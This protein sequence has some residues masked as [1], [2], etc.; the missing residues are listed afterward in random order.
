MHGESTRGGVRQRLWDSG[1]KHWSFGRSRTGSV[2]SGT[3]LRAS[4][5][6]TAFNIS[7]CRFTAIVGVITVGLMW[8]CHQWEPPERSLAHRTVPIYPDCCG[9]APLRVG[10][11]PHWKG[12]FRRK[13]I[14]PLLAWL[15][16]RGPV[17]LFCSCCQLLCWCQSQHFQILM[18]Q[19][20]VTSG[21]FWGSS[22]RSGRPGRC[23]MD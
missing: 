19:G 3:A 13:S 15:P 5:M 7:A 12:Y 22:A 11:S 10:G 2:V 1:V 23:P 14:W 4:G 20:P 21:V 8:T 18:E 9:M 16:S 6:A 17:H